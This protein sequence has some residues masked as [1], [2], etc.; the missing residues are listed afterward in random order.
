MTTQT[1]NR[2]LH[3]LRACAA[4]ALIA[5]SSLTSG[6]A[7]AAGTPQ[8]QIAVSATVV[9]TPVPVVRILDVQSNAVSNP[10]RHE[11]VSPRSNGVQYVLVEY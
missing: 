11:T 1:K 10:V 8:S 4:L 2:N 3:I 7:A 5:G 6:F 9:K